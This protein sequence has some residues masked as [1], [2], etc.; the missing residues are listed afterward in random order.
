MLK[1]SE[2]LLCENPMKAG[3]RSEGGAGLFVLKTTS[4]ICLIECRSMDED[5]PHMALTDIFDFYEFVN[6]DGIFERHQLILVF[7]KSAEVKES[8]IHNFRKILDK[9][10][11][12]YRSYIDFEDGGIDEIE[13]AKEN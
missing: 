10:W 3:S 12:W 6:A 9:S 4:P 7:P 11:R 1:I 13:Y 8:D 2:F 5:K